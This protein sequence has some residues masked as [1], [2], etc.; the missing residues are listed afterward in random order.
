MLLK[1]KNKII[2]TNHLV[3]AEYTPAKEWIDDECEPPK[4]IEVPSALALTMTSICG[5]QVAGYEGKVLGVYSKSSVITLAGQ[6]ADDVW[7]VL[8]NQVLVCAEDYAEKWRGAQ[9]QPLWGVEL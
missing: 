4:A 9:E 2:N 7:T 1:I 5:Q 3:N 8:Q 6:D